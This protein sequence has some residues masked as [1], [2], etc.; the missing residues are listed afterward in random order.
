MP[1]SGPSSFVPTTEEFLSHYALV[2]QALGVGNELVLPTGTDE[3]GLTAKK[4][5]LVA[6]RAE[7]QSKVNDKET[8]RADLELQ[9]A[10][11][12][13]R[14]GQFNARVRAILA[15]TKWVAALPDVPSIR[16][17]QSRILVPMDDGNDLWQQINADPGT[18]QP[19]TLVGGYDQASFAT[20]LAALK[21]AYT[22]L[23][24]A[25]M[26]VR[27]VIGERKEIEDDIYA[28]LL[29]YRKVVPTL[30]TK[31]D[32]LVAS[33]PRLTPAPGGTPEA[34]ILSGQWDAAQMAA[35]L[36]WSASDD[37][38]LKHYELRM[39]IG[40]DYDTENDTTVSVIPAG[41]TETETV[42]GL[43]SP[44]DIASFKVYVVVMTGNE[45]GSNTV[46]IT[47]S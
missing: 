26:A 22:A 25:E 34:V 41:T 3:A 39:T 5:S 30:F 43:A 7:Q 40:P 6:K 45:S 15:G 8:A 9:K 21:A 32:P 16:N 20:D 1:I 28:D 24:A 17:G 2:N 46:T 13:E 35:S 33:I 19:V 4:D 23:N 38:E 29:S 14:L 31:D 18:G 47:R 37:P 42:A 11:L 10:A 27:V 44:G 12:I 36:S